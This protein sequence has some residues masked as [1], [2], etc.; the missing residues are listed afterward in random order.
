MSDPVTN[1]EVE[2]VLSSIRRLVSEDKRPLQPKQAEPQTDR[3]V[4]TPALRVEETPEPQVASPQPEESQNFAEEEASTDFDDEVID[5][6]S[7]DS[8]ITD[9]TPVDVYPHDAVAED[10]E[11]EE[12]FDTEVLFDD[13]AE[14]YSTDPYNFDDEE[15]GD[16]EGDL[17]VATQEQSALDPASFSTDEE[18]Q[19]DDH[20]ADDTLES[21]ELAD[22]MSSPEPTTP[23]QGVTAADDEIGAEP[24][25]ADTK[26]ATLS[27]KIAALETAIGNISETWEPDDAGESDYAGS[28][29]EAM[30]WEDD[31]PEE[32]PERNLH[33]AGILRP[34][35]NRAAPEKPIEDAPVT[36]AAEQETV[37]NATVSETSNEAPQDATGFN[38]G[39]EE[40]LLDEE[41]LRDL[42]SEIVRAELQG[43]LGERITRNVRK[44]VRREIHRALTAQE[45]E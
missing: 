15:D 21:V 1:A 17:S 31:T 40:Q 11:V 24:S 39:D 10:E 6:T 33:F 27:A 44:L 22:S 19:S 8:L 29:P 20:Q 16:G 13:P 28:E 2:D 4:L 36:K 18:T 35:E 23:E 30:A 7:P 41:A 37:E 12:V 5:G 26:A 14:D 45:M 32:E 34:S 25:T 42:V 43:A 3:L 9:D 38:L